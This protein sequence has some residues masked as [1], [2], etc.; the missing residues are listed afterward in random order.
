MERTVGQSGEWTVLSE[1]DWEGTG[2]LVT[3]I[4]DALGALENS[5]G[6]DVLH[7]YVD[8]EAVEVVLKSGA[9]EIR[10]EYE[11]YEIRLSADG[12]ISAR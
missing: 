8:V 9:T 6:E 5:D 4:V 1:H 12:I 2:E 7:D 11:D 10:F 3:T